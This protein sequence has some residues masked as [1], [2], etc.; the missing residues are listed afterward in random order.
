MNWAAWK[1]F[2]IATYFFF[3]AT[4]FPPFA[5][6]KGRTPPAQPLAGEKDKE[7]PKAPPE[8]CRV[9]KIMPGGGYEEVLAPALPERRLQDL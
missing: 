4:T 6:N 2:W 7:N 9:Y 1:Y 3:I 5:Q 8:D